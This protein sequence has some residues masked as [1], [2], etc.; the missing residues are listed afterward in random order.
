LPFLIFTGGKAYYS[1]G[2][3]PPLV[4]SG[5]LAVDG[6]LRRAR[7]R[8]RP[9]VVVTAV[10]LALAINS[11]IGLD[12]LPPRLLNGP[13]MALN[14]DA[15]EQ[16]GWPRFI[17]AV[18]SAWH[19]IPASRRGRAVIFTSN[20]GEAGAVDVFGPA[21]G[22]PSA[23]S[24]HNAFALWGPPP[25]GAGP[26]VLVGYGARSQVAGYFPGCRHMS[27]VHNGIGLPND[28]QGAPA[29]LC[30]SPR[31]PWSRLWPRLIH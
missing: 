8:A 2:L 15:G 18:A 14:P 3:L 17:A 7:S 31:Q 24:G 1:A 20:Y 6:W 28:E 21:V 27:T 25:N 16:V 12:V 5:G 11:L 19:R 10:V 30:G 23:Y 22:L 4:A 26:V 29:L 13:V 9:I